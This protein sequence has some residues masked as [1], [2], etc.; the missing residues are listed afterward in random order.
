MHAIPNIMPLKI[1]YSA[2]QKIKKIN[3]TNPSIK[4]NKHIT[5][6][7]KRFNGKD[8]SATN[9][10]F[11]FILPI[12]TSASLGYILSGNSSS[13]PAVCFSWS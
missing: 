12:V 11:P 2:G 3:G 7:R 8:A 6:N 4:G 5:I 1:L 13:L 10:T 9:V